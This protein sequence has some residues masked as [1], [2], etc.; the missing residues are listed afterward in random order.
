MHP[1]TAA[2]LL[3]GQLSCSGPSPGPGDSGTDGGSSPA[4]LCREVVTPYDEATAPASSDALASENDGLNDLGIVLWS[5]SLDDWP[6]ADLEVSAPWTSDL[7]VV[8]WVADGSS[9]AIHPCMAGPATRLRL[10]VTIAMDHPGAMAT[11]GGY[12]DDNGE[13]TWITRARSDEVRMPAMWREVVE[14]AAAKAG[15]ED[16]RT[17]LAVEAG[18]GPWPTVAVGSETD[19]WSQ[20]WWSGQMTDGYITTASHPPD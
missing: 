12:L 2:I 10:E 14:S 6:Y 19:T 20:E 3:I 7:S 13:D 15:H 1:P 11:L 9:E 5:T 17:F 18:A 8:E 4:D 16:A